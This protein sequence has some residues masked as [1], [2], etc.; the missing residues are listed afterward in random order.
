MAQNR[1]WYIY[2]YGIYIYIYIYI[3]MV[4][5]IY[6]VWYIYIYI[7]IYEQETSVCQ[8]SLVSARS[9]LFFCQ[10]YDWRC[11]LDLVE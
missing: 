2:I 9:C 11:S 8:V 6:M 1:Q 7:Y 4:P 10:P 5:H 3:F